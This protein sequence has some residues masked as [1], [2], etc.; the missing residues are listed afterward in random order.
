MKADRRTLGQKK[1]NNGG[2]TLLEVLIV[3]VIMAVLTNLLLSAT[4]TARE[5]ANRTVCISNLR[6]LIQAASMYESDNDRLPIHYPVGIYGQAGHW[7][8]QVYPY[9]RNR[10]IFICPSDPSGGAN[11]NYSVGGWPTSYGY[12]LSDL[13]L[14]RDGSYRPPAARSPLFDDGH[15]TGGSGEAKPGAIYLIGRYDGSVEASPVGEY[16]RIGYEPAD[17]KDHMFRPLK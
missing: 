5:R 12:F 2:F 8:E 9:V 6:Q 15:H 13:W 1:K 14:G 11:S 16:P 3:L 17:G 10:A 4:M 7:Q